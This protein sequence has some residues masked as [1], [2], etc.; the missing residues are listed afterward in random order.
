MPICSRRCRAN[1][2]KQGRRATAGRC[3]LTALPQTNNRQVQAVRECLRKTSLQRARWILT[4]LAGN[5]PVPFRGI[6][7]GSNTSKRFRRHGSE[8]SSWILGLLSKTLRGPWGSVLVHESESGPHPISQCAPRGFP[9][10]RCWLRK[11]GRRGPHHPGAPSLFARLGSLRPKRA[12]RGV[13]WGRTTPLSC[14]EVN[15]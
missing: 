11:R 14:I 5:A 15:E 4:S 8:I 3:R 2:F 6:G 7:M 13:G 9:P 10:A 12:L 1:E